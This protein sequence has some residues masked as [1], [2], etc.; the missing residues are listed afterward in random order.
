MP[1]GPAPPRPRPRRRRRP[2][3]RR[4]RRSR[5]PSWPPP[6]PPPPAPGVRRVP[7]GGGLLGRSLRP[8]R[9]LFHP[10]LRHLHRV[11]QRPDRPFRRPRRHGG[12]LV[13]RDDFQCARLV[14]QKF[15]AASG[16]PSAP[17]APTQAGAPAASAAAA[18]ASAARSRAAPPSAAPARLHPARRQAAQRHPVRPRPDDQRPHVPRRRE[19][20]E[21]RA[22][23]V[24]GVARQVPQVRP[25]RRR[26]LPQ[27]RPQLAVAVG[28]HGPLRE[29]RRRRGASA[30]ARRTR[31][32]APAKPGCPGPSR[33]PRSG[34]AAGRPCCPRRSPR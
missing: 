33:R 3:R 2:G 6:P 9:R 10:G 11:R 24:V 5:P 19:L 14:R 21:R 16:R 15:S 29:R 30:P 31:R 4:P 13:L 7:A 32:S 34:P 26:R 25:H 23:R 12:P 22:G 8:G 1:A 17:A 20:R 28:R 27:V 18:P